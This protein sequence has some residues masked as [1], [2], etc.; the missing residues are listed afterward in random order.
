M[1]SSM[2]L[3]VDGVAVEIT[4]SPESDASD[5]LIACNLGEPHAGPPLDTW[6]AL[7]AANR[8][9]VRSHRSM[10][11]DPDSNAILFVSRQPLAG[12]D[13]PHLLDAAYQLAAFA[14]TWM[15]PLE[16]DDVQP[17]EPW[18][19]QNK[20]AGR[21]PESIVNRAVFASLIDEVQ[22]LAEADVEVLSDDSEGADLTVELTL[23][24]GSFRLSHGGC[25][26]SG[27]FTLGCRFGPIP[28]EQAEAVKL[29]M[30]HINRALAELTT[31]AAMGV[32]QASGAA[33]FDRTFKLEDTDGRSLLEAMNHLADLASEWRS[34]FFLE[35]DA[36]QVS[37]GLLI[38]PDIS[39]LV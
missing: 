17:L 4:H 10:S 36:D 3:A 19:A 1:A 7:L 23:Q 16:A 39:L 26:D 22:R 34:S 15:A 21:Q 6:T 38:I 29:R 35:N 5:V 20:P 31:G 14:R 8:E 24:D 28:K 32:E 2:E 25:S 27:L 13:A 18:T 11:A 37:S 9:L 12:L 30:L 33:V